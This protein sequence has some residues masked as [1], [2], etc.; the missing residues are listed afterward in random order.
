MMK[1]RTMIY[2]RFHKLVPYAILLMLISGCSI[3][4][5][6][7]PAPSSTSLT[8]RVGIVE[9][10]Q[11]IT[12]QAQDELSVRLNDGS[13]QRVGNVGDNFVATISNAR[14]ATMVFRLL[15]DS[16]DAKDRAEQEASRLMQ[17]NLASVIRPRQQLHV[18][19][20]QLERSFI[21]YL[22]LEPAFQTAADAQTAQQNLPSALQTRVR[23]FMEQLPAGTVV[24]KNQRTAE[25]VE[26]EGYLQIARGQISMDVNVGA[27]FH[28]EN[29]SNRTYTPAINLVVDAEGALTVVNEIPMEAYISSVVASEMNSEFPL[30]ALKAQ[31]ICAR[32]FTVSK[33][34]TQHPTD[35]FDLCDDVHCQVYSG[36]SRTSKRTDY[37]TRETAGYV[38]MSGNDVCE[39]FYHSVCGG[40]T[41]SNEN[42]WQG[43]PRS[44][45]RGRFDV[46]ATAYNIPDDFLQNEEN[47]VRW[48]FDSPKVYCNAAAGSGEVPSFLEYT[49]KYFR[50]KVTLSQAEIRENVRKNTGQDVGD[51]LAIRAAERAP[52]G[53]MKRMRIIGANG[54]II[55]ENDLPIRKALSVTPLYSSCFIVTGAGN[56]PAE[57]EINGAGWGHGVGMCQT[58]AAMMALDDISYRDI[59]TH[60]Y[61]DV[62]LRKIY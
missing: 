60:Y 36:V 5:V 24:L 9:H 51:I 10:Q 48:M 29:T 47:L 23:S 7:E 32:S 55:V 35:P 37:A 50:W 44:Y 33:I 61:T 15:A 42:I 59:L 25:S 31:A 45:L 2:N 38:I 26:A 22:Y 30:E 49:K 46:P 43:T 39:T 19:T 34:E 41:E 57:F 14:P 52:S 20:G 56:V 11:R 62:S 4:P 53:R 18:R 16:Y 58:G 54:T 13:L 8:I 40:H 3:V 12:F 1:H 21:Y 27:G 17:M 28:Y 6:K